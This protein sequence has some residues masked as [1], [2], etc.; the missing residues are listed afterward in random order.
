MD[1][2]TCS[3]IITFENLDDRLIDMFM[4]ERQDKAFAMHQE[5]KTSRWPNFVYRADPI[6]TWAIIPGLRS[7]RD[8]AAAQEFLDYV[9]AQAANYNIS[10]TTS[11]GEYD[12]SP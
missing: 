7:W 11:I 8:Q 4:S 9:T 6:E 3:S 12:N 10:I 5:G 1:T 2:D